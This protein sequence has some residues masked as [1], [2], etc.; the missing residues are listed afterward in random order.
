MTLAITLCDRYLISG[1]ADKTIRIWDLNNLNLLPKVLIAHD[2]IVT[3]L[4]VTNN[5]KY[6]VSGSA[7]KTIKLWDLATKKIVYTI[8]ADRGSIW[9]VAIS[10]DN[11]TIASGGLDNKVQIWD[12][13]TGNLLQTIQASSPVI[14]SEDGCYLITVNQKNQIEIWQKI[15]KSDRFI[16][17]N[18]M[19][20]QWWL[21]LGVEPNAAFTEIRE[22]YY[23][24]ARQ[25][26]PDLN[27]SQEAEAIM[28]II[29]RAYKEAQ[30]LFC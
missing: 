25:Y 20:R 10:S 29:N 17:N 23:N 6:L 14:F 1:S 4:A 11:Q 9:S 8:A 30:L 26:H 18:G 16:D 2:N 15:T 12:L 3:T 21:I 28:Q 22:A 7:D 13:A 5:G 27:T 24:L 19:V